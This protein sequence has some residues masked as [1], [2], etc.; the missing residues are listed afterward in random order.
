MDKKKRLPF[1]LTAAEVLY[2]IVF[3]LAVVYCHSRDW[4]YPLDGSGI[5]VVVL[6][7][8]FPL[9]AISVYLGLAFDVDLF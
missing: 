7:L 5:F 4:L 6:N 9:I 8:A 3:V 2:I 1:L